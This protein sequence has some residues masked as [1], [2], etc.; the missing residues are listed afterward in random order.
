MASKLYY[1]VVE[2]YDGKITINSFFGSNRQQER[3]FALSMYKKCFGVYELL[4][5]ARVVADEKRSLQ[6][7]RL[8]TMDHRA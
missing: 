2:D 8:P 1:C 5:L 7:S 4:G 6:M 3:K